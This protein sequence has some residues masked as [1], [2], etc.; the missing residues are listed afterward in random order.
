MFFTIERR[1][2]NRQRSGAF[3]LVELLVVITI[4]GILI[5]LLL[6]AVQSAREAARQ[7]QC[8]NNLKQLGLACINYESQHWCF[9]PSSYYVPGTN[10]D[11]SRTH[12]KNWVIS[13][14]PFIEQQPLHDSFDFT[15]PISHSNNRT[16]RGTDIKA[17]QC[18]TDVGHK[19]KFSSLNTSEGDNWARGN[20]AA[21]AN[22]AY[23]WD[24]TGTSSAYSGAGTT[25]P[26]TTS[27]WH[28]GVMG[29]QPL[30]G[31]SRR[32]IDGTEQHDPAGRDPRRH[33][34]GRIDAA[35]GP[36]ATPA[37]AP[38]TATAGGDDRRPP[39]P[40]TV[41][42]TTSWTAAR[43]KAFPAAFP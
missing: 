36:W 9:P 34:Q 6:P 39:T 32:S 3:T 30:D 18:P 14:L 29:L 24:Y 21:N 5:S 31:R 15:V 13:I 35:P 42:R 26:L 7:A 1:D 16:A 33:H 40:A 12:Y 22:I 41:P 38:C 2:C 27:R 23:G 8:Q 19:V 37:A 17:F 4:I 10:P 25:G 43:T 20:Y 11:Q 28:R